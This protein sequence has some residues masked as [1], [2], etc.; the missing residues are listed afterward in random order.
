MPRPRKPRSVHGRPIADGFHPN[1]VPPWGRE[2]IVLPVEG[3][4][5]IR[6]SDF[7]GLGQQ[8]AAERMNVSRQTFGRVLADARRIVA[9]ALVLGKVLRIAGGHFEMPP[10]GRG[11]RGRGRGRGH[12]F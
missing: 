4:E 11:R 5:A 10:W 8:A 9:E 6:L 1:R 12:P 7:E 3:L 2:E